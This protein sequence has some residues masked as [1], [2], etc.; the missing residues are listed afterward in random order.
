MI[1]IVYTNTNTN[2]NTNI[3]DN[4]HHISF[5]LLYEKQ[6]EFYAEFCFA[7]EKSAGRFYSKTSCLFTFLREKERKEEVFLID[8]QLVSSETVCIKGNV[9]KAIDKFI[10]EGCIRGQVSFV[11]QDKEESAIQDFLQKSSKAVLNRND[12]AVTTK[13]NRNFNCNIF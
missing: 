8:H 2:T 11:F 4:P 13:E 10:Y 9:A 5:I 3:N 6:Q 7:N 1:K 12:A